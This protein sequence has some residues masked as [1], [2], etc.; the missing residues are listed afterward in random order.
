[1]FGKSSNP[2]GDALA[3][4]FKEAKRKGG[5]NYLYFYEKL[6]QS[7]TSNSYWENIFAV[8][9]KNYAEET[10]GFLAAYLELLSNPTKE[11]WEIFDSKWIHEGQINIISKTTNLLKKLSLTLEKIDGDGD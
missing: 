4:E 3:E 9:E 11:Q 2:A 7:R 8:A 1:M 6:Y 10:L 5:K